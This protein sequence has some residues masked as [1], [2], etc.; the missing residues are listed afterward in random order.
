VRGPVDEATHG[1]IDDADPSPD[2]PDIRSGVTAGLGGGT[3]TPSESAESTGPGQPAQP[4]AEGGH[5]T[6]DLDWTD[7]DEDD[8]DAG[9]G[10][11]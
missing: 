4:G 7:T 11:T 5:V 6:A 3:G 10:R 9:S 8:P 2:D 1:E